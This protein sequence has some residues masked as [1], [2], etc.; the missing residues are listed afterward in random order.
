MYSVFTKLSDGEF[1]FQA[2]RGELEQAASLIEGLAAYWPNEYVIRDSE[3]NEVQTDSACTFR[4][5]RRNALSS[6]LPG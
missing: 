5:P 3:G 6:Q 1:L 4:D 2:S